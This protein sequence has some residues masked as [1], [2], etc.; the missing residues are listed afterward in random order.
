MVKDQRPGPGMPFLDSDTCAEVGVI[1]FCQGFLPCMMPSMDGWTGHVMPHGW[2]MG[3]M[4][5]WMD[6][7]G[8]TK[9][10]LYYM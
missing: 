6:E 10:L 3:W 7:K 8:F 5:G 2:M 9:K 4:M 1:Y